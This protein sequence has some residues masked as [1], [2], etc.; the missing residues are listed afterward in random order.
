[1]TALKDKAACAAAQTPAPAAGGGDL[2]PAMAAALEAVDAANAE[3]DRLDKAHN[4]AQEA[5]E[6]LRNSTEELPYPAI[7]TVGSPA[8]ELV[9]NGKR[10]PVKPTSYTYNDAGVIERSE[11]LTD[12]QKAE[13]LQA[14]AEHD[15]AQKKLDDES[16]LTAAEEAEE[17]ALQAYLAA[18]RRSAE[19]A[20]AALRVPTVA[21]ADVA[22]KKAILAELNVAYETEEYVEAMLAG[23]LAAIG[24]APPPAPDA[25]FDAVYAAYR[26]ARRAH[27]D[28]R[29][30]YDDAWERLN[31]EAPWPE[32]LRHADGSVF[33]H[34]GEIK[35]ST[36]IPFEKK[37]EMLA[38]LAD[39][40]PIRD[41]AEARLRLSEIGDEQEALWPAV[42][43][44]RE[45]VMQ[46]QPKT[47]AGLA[48]QL[49]VLIAEYLDRSDDS[50]ERQLS[51]DDPTDISELL[52]RNDY[53][54]DRN[55]ALLYQHALR[56]AGINSPALAA[57][58][59]DA[60]AWVA[61]FE[62]LP[63]HA[64][65]PRGPRYEESVAW[66]VPRR[67]EI[68]ITEPEA[69][70]RYDQNVRKRFTDE[71]WERYA[72]HGY[73]RCGRPFIVDCEQHLEDAYPDGGPEYDRLLALYRQHMTMWKEPPLGG[74]SWASLTKW[75]KKL[76]CEFAHNRERLAKYG[77]AA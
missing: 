1:M 59:F 71:Q 55:I 62:S 19:V 49:R 75:Q 5:A 11:S 25:A 65:A 27:D 18:D 13:M 61:A 4:A 28:A 7:L 37:V 26:E 22:A 30:R 60:E 56:L 3:A 76:V 29:Q 12:Q 47:P 2:T 52:S 24:A 57:A 48:L 70:A 33:N 53:G 9:V 50:D 64:V 63:G 36:D 6:A 16:G 21:L 72:D 31:V 15:A 77:A 8:T 45:A 73:P 35:K 67:E 34:E 66:G 14:L 44:A 58:A 10:I 32:I 46:A 41:A 23:T 69:L 51:A 40:R 74:A 54:A 38:A 68:M 42:H 17:A 20:L 39:F 43:D